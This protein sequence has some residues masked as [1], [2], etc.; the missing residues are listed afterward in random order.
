MALSPVPAPAGETALARAQRLHETA[1]RAVLDIADEKLREL[2][3]Q[4]ADLAAVADLEGMPAGLRGEFAMMAQHL[5]ARLQAA[6]SIR[7]KI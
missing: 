7:S 5:R 4:A 3:E 6:Q 1:R 2:G